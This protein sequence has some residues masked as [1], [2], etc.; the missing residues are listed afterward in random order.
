MAIATLGT[1]WLVSDR[2]AT[3]WQ[4]LWFVTGG[5]GQSGV[6]L[7]QE[8]PRMSLVVKNQLA[9]AVPFD[10]AL[11]ATYRGRRAKLGDVRVPVAGLAIPVDD[12]AERSAARVGEACPAMAIN[13]A[14]SRALLVTCNPS[15]T[16][17]RRIQT[18][19]V[20]KTRW[21]GIVHSCY[22]RQSSPANAVDQIG[23][24]AR[25]H[26]RCGTLRECRER[27]AGRSRHGEAAFFR[28]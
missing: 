25:P 21:C 17:D 22:C 20:E 14:S 8:K 10:V 23:R 28:R 5:T 2:C 7:V 12:A 4:M 6:V 16:R 19:T 9:K 24:C 27:F 26:G 18:V 3:V 1:E 11:R 15:T 13:A